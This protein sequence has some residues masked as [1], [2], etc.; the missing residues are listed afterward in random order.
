MAVAHKFH[1][2]SASNVDFFLQENECEKLTVGRNFKISNVPGK[3]LTGTHCHFLFFQQGVP[4][5][6]I[7]VVKKNQQLIFSKNTFNF[8]GSPF[9]NG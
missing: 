7:F 5:N 2:F 9:Q 3:G 6:F 1:P 8:E 4:K